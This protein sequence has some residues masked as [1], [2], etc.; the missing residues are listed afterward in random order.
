[1][2][3]DFDRMRKKKENIIN[4]NFGDR[5]DRMIKLEP[6]SEYHIRILPDVG[7]D[8]FKEVFMHYNCGVPFMCEKKQNGGKCPLCNTAIEIYKDKESSEGERAIAKKLNAQKR[9][10]SQIVLRGKD[11]SP[12]KAYVWGYSS[13]VEGDLLDIINNPDYGDVT[14]AKEG[15]DLVVKTSPKD[16]KSKFF[17][18]TILPRPK[19]SRIAAT[20]VETQKILDECPK[21]FECLLS[22]SFDEAAKRLGEFLDPNRKNSEE[23][24][25]VKS[26]AVEG[27]MNEKEVTEGESLPADNIDGLPF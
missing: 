6:S 10:Y 9:C 8:P 18:I 17:S 3:I 25:V 12:D 19:P 16:E 24:P 26:P 13:K 15:H 20:D 2:S 11:G 21:I 1:M 14:D 23:N 5:D 22:V 27:E 7:G 4:K